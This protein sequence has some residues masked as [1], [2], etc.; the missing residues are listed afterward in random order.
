MF[1][2]LRRRNLVA[3]QEAAEDGSWFS[4][5]GGQFTADFA[6]GTFRAV[7]PYSEALAVPAG[8]VQAGTSCVPKAFGISL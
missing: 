3:P 5:P 2:E 6:A 1:T 4:T 7:T 8:R